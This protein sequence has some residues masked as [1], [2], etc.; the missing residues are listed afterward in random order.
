MS[1]CQEDTRVFGRLGLARKLFA[2][3]S[4][5][6]TRHSIRM[7][8]GSKKWRSF[9]KTREAAAGLKGEVKPL[10]EF[11]CAS[12][13]PGLGL[14]RSTRGTQMCRGRAATTERS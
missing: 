6:L 8:G 11:P 14:G 7:G 4:R 2:V 1:E 5:V 10:S 12:S 3:K 13:T 9:G